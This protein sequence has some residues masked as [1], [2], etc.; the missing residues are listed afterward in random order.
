MNITDLYSKQE[1]LDISVYKKNEASKKKNKSRILKK[2]I[3]ES[4]K[5]IHKL[6][7]LLSDMFHIKP[8]K[9]Q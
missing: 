8:V 5:Y 1:T 9:S 7:S 2:L 6:D 4:D 3:E